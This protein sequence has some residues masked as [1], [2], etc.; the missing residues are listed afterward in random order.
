[1]NIEDFYHYCLAFPGTK[2]DFPFDEN[3][4]VFKVCGK[5]FALTDVEDFS[6]INLKCDPVRAIELRTRFEEV[7]P[8]YHMNKKHWNTISM[9]GS[10]SDE[11]IKELI[12]HSY[13]LVIQ[14]LPKKDKLR[15][16]NS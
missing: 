8:G 16:K 1:M 4:L 3:T 5:M 2:E 13:E 6:S 10:L 12:D 15:L 11:L 7:Q 9:K 14:K